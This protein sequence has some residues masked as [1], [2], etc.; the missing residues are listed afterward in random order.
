[1]DRARIKGTVTPELD[2]FLTSW[3]NETD[4]VVAHTSGSTGEPKE[5]RLSKA[6]MRRSAQSTCRFFGLSSESVLA[7]S[8]SAGYIAGKMVAVRA[9]VCGGWIYSEAPSSR[10]LSGA[11]LPEVIDLLSV[12]PAQVDGLLQSPALGRVRAV[13]VGGAPID[14]VTEARL[15]AVGTLA[16]YATYGMTETCSNVALRRLGQPVF[17][18][19]DGFEF[20]T[21]HRGCLVIDNPKMEFGRI[22]TNDVVRLFDST[23]FVWVGRADNVINSG[24]VK[25]HPEQLEAKLTSILPEGHFYVGARPSKRWGSEA[26]IVHDVDVDDD[27]KRQAEAKLEPIERPKAW[28]RIAE[29]PRTNTGKLKRMHFGNNL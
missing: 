12:V 9:D 24:G 15:A 11:D 20:T 10:P 2:S 26:V 4:Y 6:D 21:D 13:L 16:S 29:I 19:N 28:I 25:L 3:N 18:A 27:V 23:H 7:L 22:V 17:V 14:R 5:I 1:M 8:L